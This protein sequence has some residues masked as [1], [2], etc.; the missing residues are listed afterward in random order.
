MDNGKCR[1]PNINIF[2][3]HTMKLLNDQSKFRVW[4][5]PDSWVGKQKDSDTTGIIK[6][7]TS[8]KNQ[9]LIFNENVLH[10]FGIGLKDIECCYHV[11]ERMTSVDQKFQYTTVLD[12]LYK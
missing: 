12:D 1:I 10:P 4:N 5:C 2:Q 8:V 9:A 3:K 11:V 7:L 6:K